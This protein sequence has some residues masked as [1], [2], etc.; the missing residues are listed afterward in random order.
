VRIIEIVMPAP[1]MR[2]TASY[3][4]ADNGLL[5]SSAISALSTAAYRS[6]RR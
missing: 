5:I 3:A 4:V 2:V 1:G 6:D